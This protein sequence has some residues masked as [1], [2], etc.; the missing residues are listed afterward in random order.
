MG[1][2]ISIRPPSQRRVGCRVRVRPEHADEAAR[3]FETNGFSPIYVEHRDDGNVSFWFG[4]EPADVL[5]RIG[6]CIPRE[7]YAIQGIVVGNNYPFS[8]ARE[9]DS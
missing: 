1:Q 3:L 7:F 5:Y 9:S 8:P 2:G 6:T 4:K